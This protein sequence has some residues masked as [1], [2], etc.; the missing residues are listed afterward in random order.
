MLRGAANTNFSG[1][2]LVLTPTKALIEIEQNYESPYRWKHP[3]DGRRSMELVTNTPAISQSEQAMLDTIAERSLE[4]TSEL[5]EHFFTATD[6]LFYE[7]SERASTNNEENLYFEAMRAIRVSKKELTIDF[8]DT[9]TACFRNITDLRSIAEGRTVESEDELSIIDRE[10]LEVSLAQKNMAD[11]TRDSYKQE[12]YE[13]E[14]RLNHF[15][16]RLEID[17]SNNPIDPFHLSRAFVRASLKHLGL[18]IKTRLI[19]F[20]LFEK[21]FLKQLG[22]LYAE[23]NKVLIDAGVLPKVPRK[24]HGGENQA[25]EDHATAIAAQE[26]IIEEHGVLGPD[27]ERRQARP[28]QLETNA[29]ATLMASIRAARNASIPG[30]QAL[31]NYQY[32]SANPGAVMPV[33]ELANL[34]TDTQQKLDRR[35]TDESPQNLV[36]EIVTDILA[37]KNP[38]EPQ[39]LDQPDE[40][41]INLVAL[42]FDKV[43]EDENLPLAVQSLVCRLQ[44]P[45]LKIALHDKTFLTDENHPSRTLINAITD[46]GLSFDE[47]K[48]LEK[49][50]LYRV[51]ADGVHAINHQFKLDTHIF[52][53]V[54][55]TLRATIKAEMNKSSVVETRTQQTE[56]GKAKLKAARSFAQ[57]SLY[58]KLKGV[59]LP[60]NISDFLTSTWLQVM[61]ITFLRGGKECTEWVEYEQIISDIIW[62]SQHY[63][64]EK[65]RARQQRLAPEIVHRIESGLELII[66]NEGA[67][68]EKAN[69][70]EAILLSIVSGNSA[71]NIFKELSEEQK[72]KLGKTDPEKKTWEEMTALERQQAR[73]EELSSQFY[74]E[75]KNMPTGTWLEYL[76][77]VKS[78]NI[79]CK[80]SAKIDSD[81]YVFVNRFGFKALIKTR[82]QFAYD[83]QFKKARALDTTPIFERLMEKVVSQIQSISRDI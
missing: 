56:T 20:K 68:R 76:D 42:F 40:D 78:K 36:P 47:T 77:D 52:S 63:D 69:E 10:E 72:S 24:T 44:I 46:A 4:R 38:E 21:H 53:D 70:V 22:H 50:P 5:L 9:V 37:L 82:R 43:L 8:S 31:G 67:R 29:L 58:D 59:S 2:K 27:G 41:I 33:P 25:D 23:A 80:L 62:A 11:R 15:L 30:V 1:I 13:L 26:Q 16:T 18:E 57:N 65:S 51:I 17:Q 28:F 64:D 73:Y 45:V 66:D 83:M 32:Y 74:L 75:A 7:L 14:A 6:D 60:E 35:L 54:T 3:T 79:R 19:F 55:D 71:E 48:P 49:D 12:L 61:V 39:A 34:L 81:N